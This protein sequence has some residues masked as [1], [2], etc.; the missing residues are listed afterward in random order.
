MSRGL[1]IVNELSTS[2]FSPQIHCRLLAVI[3]VYK[4]PIPTHKIFGST[5]IKHHTG[6]YYRCHTS[7][8]SSIHYWCFD[9]HQ[10]HIST[11]ASYIYRSQLKFYQSYLILSPSI[12]SITIPLEHNNPIVF[13][14]F[15]LVNAEW[16]AILT[17]KKTLHHSQCI[18]LQLK[19]LPR[20]PML[21]RFTETPLTGDDRLSVIFITLSHTTSLYSTW[22][23]LFL[24]QLHILE[25]HDLS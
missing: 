15:I 5:S 20:R 7:L 14:P 9:D 18:L 3:L 17:I 22:I 16:A 4:Y 23:A 24:H 12:S 2:L 13:L 21:L 1:A 8:L 19:C 25:R 11:V 6:Q 10:C